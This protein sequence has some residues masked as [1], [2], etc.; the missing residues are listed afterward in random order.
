MVAELKNLRLATEVHYLSK[1]EKFILMF[2]RVPSARTEDGSD[3]QAIAPTSGPTIGD[4]L[5]QSTTVHPKLI[6]ASVHR[7]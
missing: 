1:D 4:T 3:M 7:E 6:P 2:K 5:V